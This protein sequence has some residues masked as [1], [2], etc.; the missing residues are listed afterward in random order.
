MVEEHQSKIYAN[1]PLPNSAEAEQQLLGCLILEPDLI[2]EAVV[3]VVPSDFFDLRHQNTFNLLLKMR[4]EQKPIA[5]PS[6][7]E[8]AKGLAGGR[9]SLGGIA[10]L[11]NLPNQTPSAAMLP[12]SIS[13]VKKKAKLREF[14]RAAYAV[15]NSVSSSNDDETR[16]DEVG[17]ILTPLLHEVGGGGESTT[18][19]IVRQAIG[20]IE[21]AFDLK[22]EC[23]GVSTGFLALDKQTGGLQAGEMIVLAARPSMGKTSLALNIAE[24]VSCDKGLP[25]GF[26]SLEMTS[27][28]LIKRILSSRSKVNGHKLMNGTLAEGDIQKLTA[29]A[30]EV[31]KAPLHINDLSGLSIMEMSGICRRMVT[32]HGCKLLIIDYLQLLQAKA[33]SRVQEV[34]RIS[35]AIKSVAKELG[36][37]VLILSQLS[38]SV[39]A[40]DRMPRL[41]DLRDSGA[42]EQDADI[43]LFLSRDSGTKLTTLD[44][45]K[46]RTGPT[47]VMELE[48]NAG[49][50][51]YSNPSYWCKNDA[52]PD[53]A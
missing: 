27:T 36:V 13:I 31:S 5:M 35:S 1:S 44:I 22:G 8:E 43:V 30:G 20:Q 46:H 41:S 28:S 29:V 47:G 52:Q 25:V 15:L 34:S 51:K 48:W 39:E 50:T 19:D 10:Y 49:L 9:D 11:A 16:L 6:L 17:A 4:D 32:K 40:Q 7:A 18:R 53:S 12:Y 14:Q 3:S 2:D 42:I 45:A 23:T 38:R 26:L 37:P 33:E 24:H 21:K